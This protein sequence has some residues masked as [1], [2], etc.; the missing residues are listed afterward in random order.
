MT[1]SPALLV[2][3][4]VLAST[5]PPQE[6]SFATADGGRI[7]ADL[8]GQGTDAVVLA[9]GAVFNKESWAPL[10]ETLVDRGHRVLAIDFRG[11]GA[12]KSGDEDKALYQDVLAAVRYLRERGA[13]SVAVV[14]AS[15]GGGAS[16]LAAV[17]AR[18][19][20]IDRLVLLSP[21]SIPS[22]GRMHAGRILYIASRD[23]PMAPSVREQ[24]RR[25]P[26]PKRLE[27]V[28]GDAHAQHIFRTAQGPKLTAL[29][30]EFLDKH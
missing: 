7:V 24:F 9:H 2:A 25:A 22:P 26:E 23:E 28:D 12:S 11:Y 13:T 20:E 21:V 6:V 18:A 5:V 1:L 4:A 29:I 10:A 15:M 8:Y 27:L 16:G 14:G 17:E 3:F 19:G 30:A